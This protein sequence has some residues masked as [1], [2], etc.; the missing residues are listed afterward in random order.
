MSYVATIVVPLL[1]QVDEWLDQSVRSA[2][3]QSV[4]TEVIVVRS[5]STPASNLRVLDRLAQSYPNLVVMLEDAPGSF[6]GAINK[7]I[8]AART[9]RVGLLLSDDW[10]D[11]TA[12]AD[13]LRE[14]ADIVSS[15]CVVYFPDGRVNQA[16]SKQASM[17]AFRACPTLEQQ[18]SYLKHFF[19]FRKQAVLQ[20]GGLDET[21]GSAPGI[22]D[23]DLIWTLLENGASVAIVEKQLYH[24]RDH[25]GER[26]TLQDKAQLVENLSKI[27]RKHGVW[28]ADAAEIISRHAPWYGKPMYQAETATNQVPKFLS[29]SVT[30]KE[31]T[32]P[33]RQIMNSEDRASSTSAT[34][35]IVL[36]WVGACFGT[37]GCGLAGAVVVG[38]DLGSRAGRRTVSLGSTQSPKRTSTSGSVHIRWARCG[39]RC[40]RCR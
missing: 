11:R 14:S 28:E 15:G 3:A 7:G 38:I 6:P 8:R 25:D 33:P 4:P 12:V 31:V 1:R 37:L 19:L 40:R 26:L 10:L 39:R 27:L 24:Y 36:I 18:A 21:I 35:S 32:N 13:S 17:K 16:A 2:V 34:F 5:E 22:D 20:V 29:S 9:D 30:E 23:F